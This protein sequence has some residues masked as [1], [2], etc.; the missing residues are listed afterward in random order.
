MSEAEPKIVEAV[1]TSANT[2]GMGGTKSPLA[3]LIEA[4]MSQAVT[5]AVE[6]GIFDPEEQRKLILEARDKAKREFY[7]AAERAREGNLEG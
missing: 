3:R 7:A 6:A 4:A 2:G 1:F 5:D